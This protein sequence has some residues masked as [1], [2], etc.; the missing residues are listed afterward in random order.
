ML[1][2]LPL[3]DT[4]SDALAEALTTAPTAGT[5]TSVEGG[6][7]FRR[8]AADESRR[9]RLVGRRPTPANDGYAEI[10]LISR[11]GGT[12]LL[13]GQEQPAAG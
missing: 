1:S 2:A 9:C 6:L 8:Y 5:A 7:T 10:Q 3:S 4:G 12:K 11:A 13:V